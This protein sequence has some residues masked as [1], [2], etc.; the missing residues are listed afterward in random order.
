MTDMR[1]IVLESAMLSEMRKWK[2]LFEQIAW[3]LLLKQRLQSLE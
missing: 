2:D 3:R 1:E